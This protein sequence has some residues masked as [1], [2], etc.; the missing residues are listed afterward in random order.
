MKLSVTF[1]SKHEEILELVR[2]FARGLGCP[3][4]MGP[5]ALRRQLHIEVDDDDHSLLE[6]LTHAALS[7][8][9]AGVEV[10]EPVCEVTY[11]HPGV[12]SDVRLTLRIADFQ[13]KTDQKP[14]DK[15]K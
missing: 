7:A 2:D 13:I 11:R 3:V 10:I 8:T 12:T 14:R 9:K 6:V 15:S 5:V 4:E 1:I